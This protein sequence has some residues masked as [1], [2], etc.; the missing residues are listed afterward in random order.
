M[1]RPFA[2]RFRTS[3]ALAISRRKKAGEKAAEVNA[4]GFTKM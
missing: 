1:C 3:L 4:P 2:W